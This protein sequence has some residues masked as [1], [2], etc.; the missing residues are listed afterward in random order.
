M[1]MIHTRRNSQSPKRVLTTVTKCLKFHYAGFATWS[2]YLVILILSILAGLRFEATAPLFL[3]GEVATEDVIATKSLRLEDP[4][5]TLVKREQTAALQPLIYDID[6]KS[7]NDFHNNTLD[8]LK[9]IAAVPLEDES[10]IAFQ[11]AYNAKNDTHFD[12]EFFFSLSSPK[13]Q[14]YFSSTLLPMAESLLIEGVFANS[15]SASGSAPIL[16]RD[17]ESGRETL[18]TPNAT[19]RNRSS[20]ELSVGQEIGNANLSP[21]E[22]KA[23]QQLIEEFAPITLVLNQQ[24]TTQRTASVVSAIPSVYYYIEK[25]EVVVH[26]GEIVTREQQLKMQTLHRISSG[27]IDFQKTCGV[28]ILA[29]M[30]TGA[31]FISPSA[32]PGSLVYPRVQ[33][34][35]ASLLL[36][37]GVFSLFFGYYLK[38]VTPEIGEVLP[39][40]FPLSGITAL[41]ALV[42]S[43]KRYYS[44]ALLLSLFCTVFLDGGIALFIF[45]FMSSVIHALLTL[46]ALTRQDVFYNSISLLVILLVVALGSAL[47]SVINWEQLPLLFLIIVGNVLL[48]LLVLFA[49]SPFIEVI[50]NLTTRFRLMEL[51]NFDQPLLQELMMT[52]PGT[53]NHS[54]IVAHLVEAGANAVKANELLAKVAALYHD[55][56]KLSHP[57]YFVENQGGGENKHDTIAPALS[58]L[59]LVSHVKHGVEL[60]EKHKLGKE[61]TDIIAQ[62]HG[63]RC[64]HYFYNK[65]LQAHVSEGEPPREQSFC[66]PYPKPQTK[67]A[68]LIMLADAVEA[69][70]RTLSDP[71]PARVESH[72]KNIIN[73]IYADGQLDESE[74]T[75]RDLNNVALAFTRILN[76][77][78]HQRIVYPPKKTDA[79][80]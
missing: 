34:F 47:L 39:F 74:L 65:A 44:I 69:S 57:N 67:E 66:Y 60:A 58:A 76:G 70:S 10:I 48:A 55:I 71:T 77:L 21:I 68:A 62:H 49:F 15:F 56:G 40:L 2:I 42:F 3:A 53:Y 13:V 75:F 1:L 9:D 29:V 78:F 45:F 11:E 36:V 6:K 46:N 24:A 73:G 22:R 38:S 30:F 19:T 8:L 64:I 52:T 50:F 31:L 18:L 35:F 14:G 72:V 79:K 12:S 27:S 51:M 23:V 7:I 20:F 43:A 59:I 63:N 80:K 17:I 5:A 25:G 4:H 26:E 61:I 54:T 16:I 41:T 32:Q 28:F 33:A 37:A